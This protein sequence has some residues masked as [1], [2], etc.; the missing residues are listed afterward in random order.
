M[1]T[2]IAIWSLVVLMV[3]GIFFYTKNNDVAA[4][5]TFDHSQCQYPDRQSNPVDGCDNSDPACGEIAKGASEC[6]A[7]CPA[8]TFW[9]GG[10]VKVTGCPYGD[11]I[12][13]GPECD[14]FA[15]QPTGTTADSDKGEVE[16]VIEFQGK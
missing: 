15:P 3:V 9:R 7:D 6:P 16:P 5:P 8:G 12:P 1:K 4:A 13:L 11:S 2:I 14:K 10:C